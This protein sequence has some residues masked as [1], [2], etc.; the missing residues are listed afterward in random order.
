MTYIKREA[1]VVV[2]EHYYNTITYD[3]GCKVP[4]FQGIAL[5]IRDLPAA[6]IEALVKAARAYAKADAEFWRASDYYCNYSNSKH[7]AAYDAR[8]DAL[9][10]LKREAAALAALEVGDSK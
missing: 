2:A 7:R 9:D 10:A 5:S 6:P 3:G 4:A 8:R 1:A